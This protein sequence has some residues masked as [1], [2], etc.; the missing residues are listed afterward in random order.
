MKAKDL[1][2]ITGCVQEDL[3]VTVKI[4]GKLYKVHKDFNFI[5]DDHGGKSFLSLRL[6]GEGIPF[7]N[8]KKEKGGLPIT[9]KVK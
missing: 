6:T 9:N 8:S 5:R 1:N 2:I 3:T 7:D 4:N